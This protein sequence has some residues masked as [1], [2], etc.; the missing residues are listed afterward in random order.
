MDK[1]R[2]KKSFRTKVEN[3][4]DLHSYVGKT[5][6][7]TEWIQMEQ[8]N[9]DDFARATHDPQ[10]IHTDPV[11]AEKFSPYGATI[12]HGFLVL[13]L[14]PK[15][16]YYALHIEDA[17]M[18]INYGLDK[19][20]FPHA[21]IVNSMIRGVV[22]LKSYTEIDDGAR[23]TVQTTIEIQECEKPA[24]VAEFIVQVYNKQSEL[25]E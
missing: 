15:F 20:R 25:E 19:V 22:I 18:G 17:E 5:V 2:I 11:A 12:A 1:V 23:F 13:S 16:T 7:V 14:I 21:V 3:L 8:K 10:W 6:G 24:C 4:L 9:I